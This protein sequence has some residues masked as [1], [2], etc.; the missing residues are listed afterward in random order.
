MSD[1]LLK[2]I[3]A[4][5]EYAKAVDRGVKKFAHALPIFTRQHMEQEAN[6]KLKSSKE[7]FKSALK[8][9][10]TDYVLVVELDKDSW[11]ANAVE[12]GVSPFSMKPGL[13]NSKNAK[14]SKKGY[15]YAHIPIGKDKDN[16]GGTDKSKFYQQRIQEVM[17]DP[18][19]GISQLKMQ[20]GESSVIESQKVITSDPHLQGLYR[21]RVHSS[22]SAFQSGKSKPKWGLVMFRTVSDNPESLANW[23]HPGIEPK[24]IFRSTER[25]LYEV[26]DSMLESFIQEEVKNIRVE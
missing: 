2:A 5:C 11:L 22:V 25:W 17:L 19:F 7:S 1:D 21:T 16:P 14:I 18:K 23:D 6:N 15:K 3:N 8:I 13:I 10:M 4:L 12:S 24:H 20:V 9:S 26:I